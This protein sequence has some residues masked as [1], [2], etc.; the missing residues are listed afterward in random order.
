MCGRYSIANEIQSI[1]Q[2]MDLQ[3]PQDF[4]PRYNA[5]PTQVLPVLVNRR[6]GRFSLL[7]WGIVPFWAEADK[8]KRL[9]NARAE[10][11]SSKATFRQAFQQRRCLVPAGGYF[12]WKAEEKG[13]TPFFI[14]LK[15]K[16][17]F[18]FAGLWDVHTDA[19]GERHG[20]FCIITTEAP[21]SLSHIHD[22]MP[23]ILPEE[24]WSFWLCDTEDWEG[25]LELLKPTE[26]QKLEAYPVSKKVNNVSIDEP[27]L[28]EKAG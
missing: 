2:G 10:T 7:Q 28:I 23:V 26:S 21:P 25:L 15:E 12:E 8:P 13:K 4:S 16:E 18:F 11:V 24:A 22:R 19:Q 27:S 17:A 9:I 3:V 6:P 5:A 20:D 14:R 1:A